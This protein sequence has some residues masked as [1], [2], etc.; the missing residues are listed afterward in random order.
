M[1][2]DVLH[3]PE[4]FLCSHFSSWISSVFP[5]PYEMLHINGKSVSKKTEDLKGKDPNLI[6]PKL[7]KKGR[8][9]INN[10]RPCR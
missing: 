6:S 3:P 1:S 7:C 9:M 10:F 8:D 2:C 5:F 4:R